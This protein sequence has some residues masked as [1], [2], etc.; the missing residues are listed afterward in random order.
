MLIIY[1]S[2]V[3]GASEGGFNHTIYLDYVWVLMEYFLASIP[4]ERQDDV[5]ETLSWYYAPWP[6]LDN[7]ELNR[8]AFNQVLSY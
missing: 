2:V 7:E 8:E 6:H 5:H 4:P 1:V 3:P